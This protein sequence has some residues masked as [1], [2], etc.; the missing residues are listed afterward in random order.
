MNIS[1]KKKALQQKAKGLGMVRLPR[2][3]EFRNFCISEETK[4][5]Y[6]EVRKSNE[7]QIL[8]DKNINCIE[9]HLHIT[10]N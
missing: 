10:Y 7:Y 2:Q 5:V 4:K 9:F 1:K 8:F 3:D 6:R